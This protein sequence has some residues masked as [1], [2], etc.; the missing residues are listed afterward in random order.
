MSIFDSYNDPF[1]WDYQLRIERE[2]RERQRDAD[3]QAAEFEAASRRA[4]ARK[5]IGS[6]GIATMGTNKRTTSTPAVSRPTRS[7]PTHPFGIVGPLLV[8]VASF[9][10]L[11]CLQLISASFI[12][13]PNI[14]SPVSYTHLTLPTIY[15]V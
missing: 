9:F 11:G 7:R 15:S 1:S 10:C 6:A 5:N 13:E 12:D 8:W 2:A 4:A 14:Y 3:R